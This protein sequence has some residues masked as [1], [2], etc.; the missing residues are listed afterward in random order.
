MK[1]VIFDKDGVLIDSEPGIVYA[2]QKTL[3]KYG[4]DENEYRLEDRIWTG[5]LSARKTFTLLRKKFHIE[6]PVEELVKTYNDIHVP[7]LE[8][9]PPPLLPGVERLL[10]D[11]KD[12]N[13]KTAIGTG[14]TRFKTEL[15]IKDSSIEHLL[16]EIVTVDDVPLPKPAPDTFLEAARRLGVEPVECV[17][18]G[19]SHNDRIGAKTGGMKFVFLN[20][21]YGKYPDQHIPELVIE[22]LEELTYEKLLN[23]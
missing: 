17:V 6:V 1:A 9:N 15:T 22:S 19:D 7:Y 23:L 21:F 14:S 13:I 8:S 5:G 18:I 3:G 12:N 4:V 10:Q 2:V 16:D 20:R 11:L